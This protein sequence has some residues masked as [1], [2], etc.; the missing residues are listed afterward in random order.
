MGR[1]T[2]DLRKP[3][4]PVFC[5]VVCSTPI[6]FLSTDYYCNGMVAQSRDR[7][8]QEQEEK[9]PT[10]PQQAPQLRQV[11]GQQ[12]RICYRAAECYESTVRNDAGIKGSVMH[13]VKTALD[14]SKTKWEGA[15]HRR[16]T[17]RGTPA[18]GGLERSECNSNRAESNFSLCECTALEQ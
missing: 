18:R 10:V 8:P 17:R 4:D 6:E 3:C 16:T 14:Q 7:G 11:Q 12:D 15:E 9:Q 13:S 5:L 1:T 2:R